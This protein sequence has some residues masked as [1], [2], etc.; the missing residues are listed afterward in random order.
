MISRT[1]EYAVLAMATLAKHSLDDR[2]S[3]IILAKETGIP[4]NYLSTIL[5]MLGHANLVVGVRGPGGGFS[6][7]REAKQISAH[8]IV[9]SFDNLTSQGRCL[10]GLRDC[11]PEN[12][13]HAHCDWVKVWNHYEKFLLKTTLDR[14]VKRSTKPRSRQSSRLQTR[15]RRG[16]RRRSGI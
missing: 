14:V 10:L 12:R 15:R 9:A 1:A 4:R 5:H 16:H 8:E 11:C 6:L 3:A 13:C 7:A 2:V